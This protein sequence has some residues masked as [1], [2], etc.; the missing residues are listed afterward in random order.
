MHRGAKPGKAK[1]EAKLPVA[2]KSLKNEA[3]KAR[4]LEKRLAEALEQQTAT[5][6][7]LRVISSSPTNGQPVFDTI[8]S[9]AVRL[10]G[11][12]IATVFHFDGE[13]IHIIAHH[14][15]T[16]GALAL[17][18][19]LFPAP[20]HAGS[21]TGRAILNRGVVHV[22]DALADGTYPYRDFARTAEVRSVIAVPMLRD[23]R[24]IGAVTVSRAEPGAFSERQIELLKTFADQ[25]VIAV[26]TV[27]LFTGLEA[28][29]RELTE[30]LEQQK[31]T[32]D[33]LRII[34]TSPTELQPVLDAV[35]NSAAQ[36]CGAY[37]AAIFQL[38]GESLR[39]AAHHGPLHPAIG[40]LIPVAR[41]TVAGRS[42][43][44][45]RAVHVADLPS[46]GKEFP[47]GS[48][49]ARELGHR[50]TLSVPL[51]RQGAAVG[52]IQLRRAEMNPFTD[53][54]VALLQTFADEAVIAI[55]N[56]RLFKEL[57]AAEAGRL[58][59]AQEN[60]S[61]RIARE[62]HDDLGQGLALLTV[63]MDLLRQQPPEAAGQFGARMQELMAQVRQLSSSVH[64][65]SH[66]LHPSKLDQLGLVAAIGD[67]C[68]ELTHSHGLKIEFT[69]DQMPAAISPDTAVCLYR[70]AQEGLRNAIK[71]SGAQQAEVAL[72]GTA[73]AI[74]LWIVDHG[75]GFDPRQVQGKRGL[76]L[77]SMRERVRHLGGEIAIDSQPSGG[78][79]LHVR[80]PV[81]ESAQPPTV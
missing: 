30:T 14:G 53:K 5:V 56:A 65:M 42:V 19:G 13:L 77:V 67:L 61:R 40:L 34:S 41:G 78:A 7:V 37:D 32:G 10:C 17:R 24:P 8:A 35:V 59:Q 3:A 39:L 52:T 22:E 46:E 48:A 73:D 71:H 75:R 62:L 2:S 12:R 9:S 76:G 50:T 43:L 38:D 29:N 28:R 44:E 63:K 18:R 4:Q 69:H 21:V 16:P 20:P 57:Q 11:A 70:I 26:E 31:G 45:R 36:L 47:E 80:V 27:R 55:E 49:F 6:E 60:E 74:S 54:Q 79:R 81:R 1:V 25:A 33:I 64:D 72:S 51:L 15:Y 68:R 66:R 23:G 58:L